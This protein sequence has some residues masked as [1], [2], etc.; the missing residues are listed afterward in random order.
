MNAFYSLLVPGG[1]R[2]VNPL[3]GPLGLLQGPTRAWPSSIL[4]RSR[5]VVVVVITLS[6]TLQEIPYHFL[7]RFPRIIPTFPTFPV[8]IVA[9][10][11]LV[12]AVVLKLGS[13]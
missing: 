13:A 11:A 4:G 7:A 3:C 9:V 5:A 6:G 10:N 2:R 1:R 12:G 8:V